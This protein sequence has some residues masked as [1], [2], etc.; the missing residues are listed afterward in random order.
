MGAEYSDVDIVRSDRLLR[1]DSE[2][3]QQIVSQVRALGP[4]IE[5]RIEAVKKFYE[6]FLSSRL[7]AAGIQ[8][9]PI[10]FST[11][12]IAAARNNKLMFFEA[13]GA[14]EADHIHQRREHRQGRFLTGQLVALCEK[15]PHVTKMLLERDKK[16]AKE[17]AN[18]EIDSHV[19]FGDKYI[20]QMKIS[21]RRA[22]EFKDWGADI[23]AKALELD[24]VLNTKH[25]IDA[26]IEQILKEDQASVDLAQK[27]PAKFQYPHSH[28]DCNVPTG[29]VRQEKEIDSFI[30][31]LHE[32]LD[33]LGF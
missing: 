16:N 21:K 3:E 32:E 27:K 9:T 31:K 26:P 4:N 8:N 20:E 5:N 12:A 23:N 19:M 6:T 30:A 24:I 15:I 11:L 1:E 28:P 29:Y 22:E 25:G 14:V 13:Y 2:L 10:D 33:A 7:E 18:Y 17:R